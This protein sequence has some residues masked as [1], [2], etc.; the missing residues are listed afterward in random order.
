MI[1][2]ELNPTAL[3]TWMG[4]AVF[5]LAGLGSL[6]AL[7]ARFASRRD[8]DALNTRLGILE[9]NMTHIGSELSNLRGLSEAR[10]QQLV[11]L[12]NRL[13]RMEGRLIDAMR[14]QRTQ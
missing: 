1:F 5:L 4:A 13:E 6:A 3:G 7:A 14:K 8:V 2:G 12:G 9:T 11:E 10:N